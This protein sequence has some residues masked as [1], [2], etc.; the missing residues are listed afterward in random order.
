MWTQEDFLCVRLQLI[1]S[2]GFMEVGCVHCHSCGMFVFGR[3][4]WVQKIKAASEEFIETE[5]SKRERV[6]QGLSPLPRCLADGDRRDD[7]G[8]TE[9]CVC[10]FFQ[11]GQSR[12]AESAGSSSP[13]W[14][15]LSSR[16]ANPT[17]SADSLMIV[18][19]I[20]FN[21]PVLWIY[22]TYRFA[23]ESIESLWKGEAHPPGGDWIY[24]D[25]S[26]FSL[27]VKPVSSSLRLPAVGGASLST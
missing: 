5:K 10:V 11:H 12:A 3:T 9:L 22:F 17:V 6:Y 26:D 23:K 2:C 4:A 21:W 1:S 18:M 13:F 19:V 14:R 27:P 16:R 15:P 24:V 20:H 25:Q 8:W 7:T